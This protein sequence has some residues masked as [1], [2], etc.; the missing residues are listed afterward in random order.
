MRCNTLTLNDDT[1]NRPTLVFVILQ[2][3]KICC[4]ML[5]PFNG[6]TLVQKTYPRMNAD[7][8]LV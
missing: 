2:L 4:K 5:K 1:F 3:I 6:Q 8:L 7:Y